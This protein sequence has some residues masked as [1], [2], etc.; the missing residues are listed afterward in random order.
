MFNIV[1]RVCGVV[2]CKFDITLRVFER[3]AV[4]NVVS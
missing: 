3:Y 4:Q 1:C 2:G